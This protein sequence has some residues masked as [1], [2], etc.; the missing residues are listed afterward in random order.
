MQAVEHEAESQVDAINIQHQEVED[1]KD[2]TEIS[3]PVDILTSK[4]R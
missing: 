4:R 3:S 1:V 2:E